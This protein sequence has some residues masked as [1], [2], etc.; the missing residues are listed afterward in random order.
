MGKLY[1]L[2]GGRPKS[3]KYTDINYYYDN[4]DKV[5]AYINEPLSK[6]ATIQK[7]IA[8]DVKNIGGDGK[9]HGA[10]IDIDYYNHIYV[11]PFDSAITGYWASDIVYKKVFPSIP[12]LLKANCPELYQ[13]YQKLLDEKTTN[14]FSLKDCDNVKS[15]D[16]SV[17][18][19]N[20]DIYKA[21][22]KIKEMQNLESNILSKWIEPTRKRIE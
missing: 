21:S 1:I 20:T 3:L 7:R 22:L 8:N 9:I 13:N 16:S 2:Y 18:W 14:I 10:I 17:I 4:M 12:R 15:N 11:N 6:Y 5:I 19:L